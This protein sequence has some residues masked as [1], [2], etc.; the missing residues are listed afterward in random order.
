M[1]KVHSQR[2]VVSN[3]MLVKEWFHPSH[4]LFLHSLPS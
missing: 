1:E 3:H 4:T 2:V